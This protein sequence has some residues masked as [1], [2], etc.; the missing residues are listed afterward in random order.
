[1]RRPCFMRAMPSGPDAARKPGFGSP[2]PGSAP[3]LYAAK[4][5][6]MS[7]HITETEGTETVGTRFPVE[8]V[9]AMGIARNVGLFKH[10]RSEFI[11]DCLQHYIA[12]HSHVREASGK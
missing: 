5:F 9:A 8:A 11:R 2:P 7:R 12:M 4:N 3:S 10:S 6:L 1:M